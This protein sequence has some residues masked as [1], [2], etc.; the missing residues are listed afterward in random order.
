MSIRTLTILAAIVGVA[1]GLFVYVC[2]SRTP[3]VVVVPRPGGIPDLIP[4]EEWARKDFYRS[5]PGEKPLNWKIAAKAEEFYRTEP[6]GRFVLHENDCSDFV[7]SVIDDALGAKA[8]FRRDSEDH[9]LAWRRSPW[10]W[11]YW[12]REHPLLP[13]DEISVEHSPHYAPHEGAIR[14]C[15][16]VGTDGHVYDWTKLKSWGSDR[17][18]RHSVEWFTRHSPNPKGVIVRRLKPQYRYRV[19]PLPIPDGPGRFRRHMSR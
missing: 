1:A 5:H 18:G 7:D 6:M 16:I 19:E 15:G 14:H 11:F 10:D 13:G 12:D 4:Y 3:P 2:V 17:Y 8:R 9:L